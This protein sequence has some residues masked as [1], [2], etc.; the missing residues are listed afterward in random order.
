M[1]SLRRKGKEGGGSGFFMSQIQ[2]VEID[3]ESSSKGTCRLS[4]CLV[5]DQIRRPR[6]KPAIGAREL[7]HAVYH[8]ALYLYVVMLLVLIFF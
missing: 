6:Y 5:R 1:K 2:D 3:W 8:S 7:E 4:L